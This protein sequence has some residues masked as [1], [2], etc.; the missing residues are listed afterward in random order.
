[1][2][3]YE[4]CSVEVLTEH[5]K[6]TSRQS[7]HQAKKRYKHKPDVY[8]KIVDAWKLSKEISTEKPLTKEN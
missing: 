4:W 5:F 1:M 3:S 6:N 2:I 8:K 7:Y